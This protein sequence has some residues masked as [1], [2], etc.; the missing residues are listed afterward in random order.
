MKKDESKQKLAVM[1]NIIDH[2]HK[3]AWECIECGCSNIA[4]NSHLL[5]R[6]GI[7]DNITENDH[8][9]EVRPGD[10]MKWD[11]KTPP[12]FMFKLVGI[13][14]AISLKIFCPEHDNGLFYDIEHGNVDFDVYR[15]QLLF[16]YRSL[17]AEIRKKEINKEIN[18]RM[19]NSSALYAEGSDDI[20]DMQ[21]EGY[22]LGLRDLWTYRNEI[23][24]ELDSPTGLFTFKHYSYPSLG[25]YASSSFSYDEDGSTALGV[26]KSIN[27]DV[28][29]NC[30]IHILPLENSTEII[31]GYSNNHTNQYLVEYINSWEGLDNNALG[32]KLTDLFAGH[33]ESWGLAPSLYRKLKVDNKLKYCNYM[34]DHASDY[35]I[36][37]NVGFN[38]FEGCF[39]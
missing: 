26:Q 32:L 9:Y 39:E 4:I 15:V 16:S 24:S 22:D 7:L 37:Q 38:L 3:M 2:V 25:I 27:G 5:Q 13:Q 17:C 10:M 8:S 19:R 31:V 29:D 30:F 1:R 28:W 36:M 12:L 6:H 11:D 34:R 33:I 14:Q 20:L 21:D 23:K 18:K 35:Q